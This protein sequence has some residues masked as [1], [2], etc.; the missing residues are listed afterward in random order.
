MIFRL[1]ENACRNFVLSSYGRGLGRGKA[2]EILV[3]FTLS[4]ALSH[5]EREQDCGNRQIPSS[6][7]A[8]FKAA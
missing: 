7:Q 6:S 8:C 1:P 4:P 2:V 5:G 3:H